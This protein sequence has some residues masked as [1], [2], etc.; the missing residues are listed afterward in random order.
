MATATAIARRQMAGDA[1]GGLLHPLPPERLRNHAKE[2]YRLMREKERRLRGK[3]ILESQQQPPELFKLKQFAGA[4][5][6]VHDLKLPRRSASAA[7]VAAPKSGTVSPTGA[8]VGESNA[9]RPS[10]PA[11]KAD[12]AKD[13]PEDKAEEVIDLKEFEA[14]VEELKRLHGNKSGAA[15]KAAS[16]PPIAVK[17]DADGCPAYLRRIKGELA[18]QERRAEAARAP[19]DAPPGHRRLPA[20]QVAE[21]LAA[22]KVK[23]EEIEKE[24]RGLPLVIQ[25]DSQKRRQKVVMAKIEES[26][27]ALKLFSQPVVFVAA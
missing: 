23:R 16:R 20:E 10:T 18:E 14:K 21:T 5:A 13:R 6:R 19:P 25:T 12:E 22:L 24:F 4:K 7:A 9:E 3:K 15:A 27:K 26:D 11:G 8:V 1:A 2:N 17:K